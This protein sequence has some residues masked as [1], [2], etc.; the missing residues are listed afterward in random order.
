ML[1]PIYMFNHTFLSWEL[2]TDT[3]SKNAIYFY[4][5]LYHGHSEIL[6]NL[7][8]LFNVHA[9]PDIGAIPVSI[10]M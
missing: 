10:I 7:F 9:I 5:I 2:V 8:N 4:T 1:L 3:P 6:P